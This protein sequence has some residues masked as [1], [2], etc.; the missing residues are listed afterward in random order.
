VERWPL[1]EKWDWRKLKQIAVKDSDKVRPADHPDSEFNYLSLGDIE[2]GGWKPPKTNRVKGSEVRSTNIVFDTSHVLYS[3]LR[4]YL[5]KV[6]VPQETG[7]G[8]T[9]LVPLIPNQSIILREYLGWYLRSPQFVNYA[10]NSSTGARMPRLRM[11]SLWSTRVPVPPLDVQHRLV[12]RIKSLFAE[13]DTAKRLRT[14]I[15]EEIERLMDTAL[16]QAFD[17]VEEYSEIELGEI[18]TIE[19]SLID[20]TL[21]EFRDLPHINGTVI[22]SSTGRLGSY[23][24]A[25]ED[26]MTSGKYHFTAGAV[27]YSK[28]RPYL[29]KA[30]VVDFEGVCSADMYPLRVE[31]DVL[32]PQFLQ[33]ALLSHRFT[34]YAADL[35]GRA[36]MP[37]LNRK[38]IFA[39][40]LHMPPQSEQ[41]RIVEYLNRVQ[42]HIAELQYTADALK[43][44]LEWT[45]QAILAQAFRGK[46]NQ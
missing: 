9:E 45:E 40:P 8:S 29:R 24:T 33:W 22:E 32:L 30:T 3:K 5:N 7:I 10:V 42:N 14:M 6:V 41:R 12:A 16:A 44:D 35:S 13:V 17:S 23:N 20:P 4:P 27:L 2:S 15:C 31:D 25:A 36:R 43:D 11:S 28:I 38:Q 1:P 21:P 34:A 26:G 19:A 37:K 39:Y 18:V 46:L